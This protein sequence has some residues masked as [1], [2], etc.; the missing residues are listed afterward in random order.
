MFEEGH[1]HWTKQSY[2]LIKVYYS[3][4]LVMKEIM[5]FF[6]HYFFDDVAWGVLVFFV[7]KYRSM[8]KKFLNQRNEKIFEIWLGEN[9]GRFRKIS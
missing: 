1:R 3:Y 7:K 5:Y 4:V 6:H 2:D 9:Y 8:S